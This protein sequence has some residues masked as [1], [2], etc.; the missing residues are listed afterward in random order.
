VPTLEGSSL[1]KNTGIGYKGRARINTVAYS[2]PSSFAK[3]K[4]LYKI[5]PRAL[6]K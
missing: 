5:G 3:K 2:A 4:R 1:P 6:K